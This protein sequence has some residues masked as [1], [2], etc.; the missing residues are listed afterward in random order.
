[1]GRTCN[2]L[3]W[4]WQLVFANESTGKRMRHTE[5]RFG[6]L[7]CEMPC[8]L[9]QELWWQPNEGARIRMEDPG[10]LQMGSTSETTGWGSN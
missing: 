3:I 8:I 7:H 6:M 2:L 5:P 9:L 1:M 4:W 10:V